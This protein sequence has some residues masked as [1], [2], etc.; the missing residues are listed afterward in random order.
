MVFA[1]LKL[2]NEALFTSLRNQG[3]TA[4]FD[5]NW[6]KILKSIELLESNDLAHFKIQ[7]EIKHLREQAAKSSSLDSVNAVLQLSRWITPTYLTW[8]KNQIALF[9]N[10][11]WWDKR[12]AAAKNLE[13][14][15]Q[16]KALQTIPILQE[17]WKQQSHYAFYST[18]DLINVYETIF[19]LFTEWLS[20]AQA[21]LAYSNKFAGRFQIN[22]QVDSN[23]NRRVIPN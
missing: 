6:Q 15:A 22:S 3:F 1:F 8:R 21:E 5:K 9:N 18:I 14:P 23:T 12:L 13:Q 10:P 20:Y 2:D 16:D 7:Q 17:L 11:A 4:V 19:P